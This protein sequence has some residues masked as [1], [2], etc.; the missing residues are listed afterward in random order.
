METPYN[1]LYRERGKKNKKNS[2]SDCLIDYVH[3][4]QR[5]VS[6][7]LDDLVGSAASV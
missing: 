1:C 2:E 3:L 6:S 5:Y 7:L 4:Y